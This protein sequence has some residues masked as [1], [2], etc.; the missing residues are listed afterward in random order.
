M[1]RLAAILAA[2]ARGMLR[3][4]GS[5]LPVRGNNFVLALLLVGPGAGF[6]LLLLG[7]LLL[8]PLIADPL[9]R[10]PRERLA[11]W[12]LSDRERWILRGASLALS[13]LTWIAVAAVVWQAGWQLGLGALALLALAPL[14]TRE[15]PFLP[16]W[17]P[18]TGFVSKHLRDLLTLFDVWLAAL[19]AIAA[20]LAGRF[21]PDVDPA[22]PF[23]LSLLVVLALSTTALNHFGMGHP[24]TL[25]RERMLPCPA[26]RIILGRNA[27][28][29][30]IAI[31]CVLPLSPLPGTAAALAAVAAGN[32]ASLA[33]PVPLRRW[34]LAESG[35]MIVGVQQGVA[36]LAAGVMTERTTPWALLVVAVIWVASVVIAGWQFHRAE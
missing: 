27:A 24:E 15:S 29:L 26:W 21:L 12:P 31:A 1:A 19:L 18:V 6:L 13:P 28:F 34:R 4:S 30:L 23:V 25:V 10:I 14:L 33:A 11:L 5:L 17:P 32:I 20:L 2:V 9:S 3:D 22:M 7:A 36:L 8:L 35:S 16:R